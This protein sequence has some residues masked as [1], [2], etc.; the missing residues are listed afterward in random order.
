MSRET[1]VHL[2]A[3]C[4]NFMNAAFRTSHF[5]FRVWRDYK[6]NPTFISVALTEAWLL[7]SRSM[8][9]K[10]EKKKT[11]T[12]WSHTL[13]GC[14][15]HLEMTRGQIQKQEYLHWLVRLRA[16]RYKYQ[17]VISMARWAATS[18]VSPQSCVPPPPPSEDYNRMPNLTDRR[19]S[20]ELL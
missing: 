13:S 2:K 18:G 11:G 9:E 10:E 7:T 14:R 15:V 16:A 4:S 20:K 19:L 6:L 8:T 1:V 12:A 5:M 3:A 17:H